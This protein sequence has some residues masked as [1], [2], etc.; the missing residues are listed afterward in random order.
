V[1]EC[2]DGSVLDPAACSSRLPVPRS[3]IRGTETRDSFLGLGEG[4]VGHQYFAVSP[5]NGDGT[6][7]SVTAREVAVDWSSLKSPEN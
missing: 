1:Q 7:F 2:H 5:A 4:T 3:L 6:V